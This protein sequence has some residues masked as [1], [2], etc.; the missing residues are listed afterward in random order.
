MTQ[1]SNPWNGTV[2][3]LAAQWESEGRMQRRVTNPWERAISS[4]VQS[5]R[6][7]HSQSSPSR[8]AAIATEPASDWESGVSRMLT[9]LYQTSQRQREKAT[10]KR[11]CRARTRPPCRYVPLDSR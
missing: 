9:S 10:W 11:W 5:W 6:I 1:K 8:D 3:R 2:W 4:M 7:R